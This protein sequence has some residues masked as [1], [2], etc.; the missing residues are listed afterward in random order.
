MPI[1][2]PVKPRSSDSR[3]LWIAIAVAVATRFAMLGA[4][5]LMDT[6]EARYA[7]IARRMLESGDWV[8]QWI[9]QSVPFWGK[10]PLS[11][12]M[13]VA[14]FK[15]L[16]VG[17]FAARLP[18]WLCGCLLAWIVWDWLAPRS[19]REARFAL[20]I[21]AGS[22]LFYAATGTVM[23]D[24]VLALGMT[25]AMRGFW[26]A[27]HGRPEKRV[28]EQCLLFLGIAIGLMAKG[29]IAILAGVP[30]GIW[31]LRSGQVGRV[32]REIH[33]GRGLVLTLAVVLPW[34]AWAESRTPGFL[35]YFLVGEHWHRF[36]VPG[37][38]GDLYGSAHEF[39]RGTIW[40]FALLAVFPWSL[41]APVAAW[42][43]RG[44]GEPATA[45]DRSLGGYLLLWTLTPCV[46]FTAAGNI[47]W[48][49]LLPGIPAF[50]MAG[51]LWLN[52][53]PHDRSPGRWL[54]AGVAFTAIA[55]I[56][57]VSGFN[58]GDW[59]ERKSAKALIADYESQRSDG[60]AL[61]F[62]R[63]QPLSGAFYSSGRA[64]LADGAD[65]LQALLAANA[66]FVAVRSRHLGRVPESLSARLQLVGRHGDYHLFRG[67]P[68]AGEGRVSRSPDAERADQ[69]A[70]NSGG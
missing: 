21:M 35:E 15:V 49:Y 40:L 52:R 58:M 24:M 8:T 50:A 42:K 3:L 53:L 61:V 10:P 11:T 56:V 45:D 39:P 51:A 38:E 2:S 64:A 31:A 43:W 25:L 18:Y 12:W 63:R 1:Q 47:L 59:D 30:L 37:W 28:R 36:Q 60:E 4:Y 67:H 57:V 48:T 19:R 65:D 44:A 46:F 16:G 69:Q 17:E 6:T 70:V 27:L 26:L 5:P 29:P 54:A 20:A 7:E 68:E 13:T 33:W 55:S 22:T 14:S 66:A 9:G 32:F 41:L 62:F 34:Y 23:T